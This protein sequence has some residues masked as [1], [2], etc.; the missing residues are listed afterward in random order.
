MRD[1]GFQVEQPSDVHMQAQA[2]LS[3]WQQ[4]PTERRRHLM[5]ALLGTAVSWVLAGLLATQHAPDHATRQANGSQDVRTADA[6]RLIQQGQPATT[7]R[8]HP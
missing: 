8:S 3:R 6:G 7:T 5:L 1:D 2:F 4:L